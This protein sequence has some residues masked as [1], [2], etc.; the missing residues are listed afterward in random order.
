M[1]RHLETD[2]RAH[3]ANRHP[4]VAGGANGDAVLAEERP[5]LGVSSLR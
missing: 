2:A 3:Y 4:Q 5:E 1:D